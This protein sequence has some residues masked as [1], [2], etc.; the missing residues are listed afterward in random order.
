[1]ADAAKA[2]A[3]S[4][5]AD[6]A[7]AAATAARLT[8]SIPKAIAISTDFVSAELCTT[9]T[10]CTPADEAV[11]CAKEA[12]AT[13]IQACYRGHRVRRGCT[14]ADKA[15]MLPR[16]CRAGTM[17]EATAVADE[18]PQKQ[19]LPRS[20]PLPRQPQAVQKTK[21]RPPREQEPAHG[22]LQ[23]DS[24]AA[25]RLQAFYRGHRARAIHGP[26]VA[27]ARARAAARVAAAGVV[28]TPPHQL[29]TRRK[30]A[31]A[32]QR[33]YRRHLA[34]S[35]EPVPSTTVVAGVVFS[36]T[37]SSSTPTA[38][39]PALATLPPAL[40]ASALLLVTPPAGAAT[41]SAG[42]AAN[43][44]SRGAVAVQ[45]AC[46]APGTPPPHPV[47]ISSGDVPA[48]CAR[49]PRARGCDSPAVPLTDPSDA[50]G[51]SASFGSHTTSAKNNGGRDGDDGSGFAGHSCSS[52]IGDDSASDGEG[53]SAGDGDDG[54]S[55][56]GESSSALS[57]DGHGD[58]EVP[59]AHSP[60]AAATASDS[61]AVAKTLPIRLV[62]RPTAL[63]VPGVP[64]AGK[65]SNLSGEVLFSFVSPPRSPKAPPESP[66]L[67]H[68]TEAVPA[69]PCA[70]TLQ[71]EPLPSLR[72]AEVVGRLPPTL[73][74]AALSPNDR[75]VAGPS[76][77]P[78]PSPLCFSFS[79]PSL[80]L[81]FL[82]PCFYTVCC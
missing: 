6:A 32:I 13:R 5:S 27:Q 45:C 19:T 15:S 4:N 64:G 58:G 73:F 28:G 63:A 12:A 38:A 51:G 39:A 49:R 33:Q 69:E 11:R 60:A 59:T 75:G 42:A 61:L 65:D 18:T 82:S 20:P 62:V 40:S 1:L 50:S 57:S 7:R 70:P 25:T 41:I 3:L 76:P 53:S 77:S 10:A 55:S 72:N 52:G 46:P 16:A 22:R 31:L 43:A 29:A 37:S 23:L 17:A 79:L 14:G 21:S 9:P 47:H 67:S 24:A 66:Q 54:S 44:S 30:A 80:S 71:V 78:P 2:D 34:R 48:P 26:L 74:R 68:G 35:R 8:D 56:G 36:S 81:L